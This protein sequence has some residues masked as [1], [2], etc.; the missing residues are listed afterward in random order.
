MSRTTLSGKVVL[1][2]TYLL[3][4]SDAAPW[5]VVEYLDYECP[6][7][8]GLAQQQP[9]IVDQLKGGLVWYV[10]QSPLKIH[11]H[12]E[13]LSRLVI[14]SERMGRFQA[15]HNWLYENQEQPIQSKVRNI[16]NLLGLS[17]GRLKDAAQDESI[18][19]ELTGF[20][21]SAKRLSVAGTPTLFLISPRGAVYKGFSAE[22]VLEKVRDNA[23]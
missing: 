16:A 6:P 9:R 11:P 18:S 19:R 1:A 23:S 14:L 21:A 4:G 3:S 8:A 12:A 5:K 10:G 2:G 17:L 15:V 7:C 20:R 22:Q 13:E